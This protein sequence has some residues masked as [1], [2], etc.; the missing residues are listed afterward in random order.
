MLGSGGATMN[1]VQFL[2]SKYNH[3]MSYRGCQMLLLLFPR[4]RN[5]V[6]ERWKDF[7]HSHSFLG[8]SQGKN[9]SREFSTENIIH[10]WSPQLMDE[11]TTQPQ[12]SGVAS[13]IWNPI[14]AER[15]NKFQKGLEE[16]TWMIEP[17]W[18]IKGKSKRLTSLTLGNW[19][20]WRQLLCLSHKASLATTARD[21]TKGQSKL[22]SVLT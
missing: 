15:I 9:P 4:T 14:K 18:V 3:P 20:H 6:S 13:I 5:L 8:Q 7:A 12:V 17:E 21:R 16:L 2:S 22:Y 10:N 1:R 11:G 19:L